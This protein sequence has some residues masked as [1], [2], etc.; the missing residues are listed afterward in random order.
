MND[1]TS[2]VERL[3]ENVLGRNSDIN[4]LNNWINTLQL[5]NAADVAKSFFNSQE[6][7]IP[8]RNRS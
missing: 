8:V 2:F 7:F 6:F 1:I 5:S 3:Y 4:G